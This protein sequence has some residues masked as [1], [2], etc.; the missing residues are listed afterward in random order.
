MNKHNKWDI[1]TSKLANYKKDQKYWIGKDYFIETPINDFAILVYN[2]LEW[3]MST[4]SGHLA[5]Y[6][7][8][9]NPKIVLNSDKVDVFFSFHKTFSFLEKSNIIAFIVYANKPGSQKGGYPF[10]LI[11]LKNKKFGFIEFE[12]HTS[13][14]YELIEVEKGKIRIFLPNTEIFKNKGVSKNRNKELI[15]LNILKW[16]DL[17]IFNQAIEKYHKEK[18]I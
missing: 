9:N 18:T 5:I 12:N 3:R 7:N 10:I 2:I 17:G 4:Y 8:H 13:I 6:S 14:Y 1:D 16:F 11:D 15:D